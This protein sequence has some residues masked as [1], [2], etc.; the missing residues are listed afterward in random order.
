ML[1]P[2][3]LFSY[4]VVKNHSYAYFT[5][6]IVSLKAF[7]NLKKNPYGLHFIN[8]FINRRQSFFLQLFFSFL[9]D[10][11]PFL[12][13]GCLSCWDRYTLN[14]MEGLIHLWDLTHILYDAARGDTKTGQGGGSQV[15]V[16]WVPKDVRFTKKRNPSWY[17]LISFIV[18]TVSMACFAC[19][20]FYCHPF[21]ISSFSA[22]ASHFLQL[23]TDHEWMMKDGVSPLLP[24]SFLAKCAMKCFLD[25]KFQAPLFCWKHLNCSVDSGQLCSW[26]QQWHNV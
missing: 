1:F 3:R 5:W 20:I 18:I 16:G 7:W 25:G 24:G 9:W 15:S 6:N 26:E 17:L 21:V 2:V 10:L 13:L 4:K 14:L 12:K 11:L 22:E 8:W 23:W 19:R